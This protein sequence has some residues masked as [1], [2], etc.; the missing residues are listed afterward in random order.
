MKS[1]ALFM[2][3]IQLSLKR[4]VRVLEALLSLDF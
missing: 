1:N 4:I 3:Q 2:D